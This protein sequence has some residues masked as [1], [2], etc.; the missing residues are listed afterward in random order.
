MKKRIKHFKYKKLLNREALEKAHP[1][2]GRTIYKKTCGA[3]HKLYND[4]GDVGPN[5]TGSNR[6]NLDYIL[7]NLLDPSYDVADGYKMVTIATANGRLISGIIAEEDTQKLVL[8]TA[9][10][11]RVV[12]A[13]DDIDAR[14][15][16]PLSLM[17]DGQLLKMS[18]QEVLDLIKYLRTTQQ[19]ELVK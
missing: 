11:P 17:P 16:S 4:G 3:C 7:L 8:K 14:K 18:D 2:R 1:G 12:I 6:A 10:Q 9:E 19:V 5:L 15:T 13:K